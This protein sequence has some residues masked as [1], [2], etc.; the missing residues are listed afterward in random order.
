MKKEEFKKKIGQ[1]KKEEFKNK[2][3]EKNNYSLKK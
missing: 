2:L 1:L 3:K